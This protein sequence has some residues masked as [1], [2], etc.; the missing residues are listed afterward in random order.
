MDN[1]LTLE[2][3]SCRKNDVAP[4]T[5]PRRPQDAPKSPQDAPRTPPG[6]TH[7]GPHVGTYFGTPDLILDPMLD[8]IFGSHFWTPF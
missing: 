6:G 3:D 4:K 2:L 5:P 8:R 7:F 1:C